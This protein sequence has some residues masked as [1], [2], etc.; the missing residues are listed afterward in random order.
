VKLLILSDLHIEFGD[1]KIPNVDA[2]LVILAGDIHV[3]DKG[4]KW[5]IR[6]NLKIPVIYVLGNH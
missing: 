4:L 5:I 3:K 2:D 6:Q 1:F